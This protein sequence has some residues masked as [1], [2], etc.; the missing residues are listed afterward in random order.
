MNSNLLSLHS[1]TFGTNVLR[2]ILLL[3]IITSNPILNELSVPV[4]LFILTW[5][6]LY[7]YDQVS[8]IL[9]LMAYLLYY[10][11]QPISLIIKTKSAL[12]DPPAETE[13]IDTRIEEDRTSTTIHNSPYEHLNDYQL[14]VNDSNNPFNR[15]RQCLNEK[16]GFKAGENDGQPGGGNIIQKQ[17]NHSNEV[18]SDWEP[19]SVYYDYTGKEPEMI[20][21]RLDAV[22][23]RKV[24]NSSQ[25]QMDQA[26]GIQ[27]GSNINNY[28]ELS[29]GNLRFGMH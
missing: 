17:M 23:N 19:Y 10:N 8:C 9:Y 27:K 16:P 7:Y 3:E 1:K 2:G 22:N 5:I 24:P 26:L 14:G 11:K 25:Q 15:K 18:L 6:P 4:E 13:T 12:N 20:P 29:E 28:P 21:I